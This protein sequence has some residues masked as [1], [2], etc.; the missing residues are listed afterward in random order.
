MRHVPLFTLLSMVIV[1][2]AGCGGGGDPD[3]TPVGVV[4]VVTLPSS[5]DAGW[6][7]TG[8]A[9]AVIEGSGDERHPGRA[10]GAWTIVWDE[11]ADWER[12]L[13]QTRTLAD[14]D[15]IT[16]TGQYIADPPP[17]VGS[18][19]IDVE[20]DDLQIR[21]VLKRLTG[22]DD[23]RSGVGDVVLDDLPPGPFTVAW[24]REPG[25]TVP[26]P[27]WVDGLITAGE[28]ATASVTYTVL[29][30]WPFT[31]VR[32]E[33]GS[34][35]MGSAAPEPGR[36]TDE[37]PRHEVTLTRP[38]LVAT[39]E[40]T[41]GQWDAVRRDERVEDPTLANQPVVSITWYD[42]VMFCNTK[43]AA[44]GLT[45]AYTIN[46]P[47]VAW[48]PR[49]RRL[50]P[51][52]RGRVGGPLPGRVAGVAE[53]RRPDAPGHGRRPRAVVLRLVGGQ[54]GQPRQAGARP[55]AQ[56]AGP[57]R[58]PRQPAGMVLGPLRRRLLHGCPCDRPQRA[59]HRQQPGAARRFLRRRQPAAALRGPRLPRPRRRRGD[60]GLPAGAQRAGD[61]GDGTKTDV[62]PVNPHAYHGAIG[63]TALVS[64]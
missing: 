51:A 40:L 35:T 22:I 49:R 55:A 31:T 14:G 1:L 64:T 4:K 26:A 46:G 60:R 30:A 16:F 5:L 63:R 33:A 59:G 47:Q 12:P 24:Q 23:D 15:S 50:A 18:L 6:T 13:T 43:S 41:N 61:R 27:G 58:R 36:E 45:A 37:G 9:G 17:T 48:D 32:L 42:A 3:P 28:T 7:L 56:P 19:T 52:D 34:F 38:L 25:W 8:P 21:W 2:A 39:T 44:D 57:L 54:L 53:R 62:A 20:P 11:I 29:P 10:V